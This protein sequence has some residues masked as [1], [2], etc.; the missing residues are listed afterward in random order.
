[1]PTF[2][3]HQ[4]A[5]IAEELHKLIAK[6]INKAIEEMCRKKTEEYL[7]AEEVAQMLKLSK[8]QI[9][10][11]KDQ[12]G[13][14]YVGKALRFLKSRVIYVVESGYGSNLSL[15]NKLSKNK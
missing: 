7:T 5:L 9:Y 2:T 4:A 3:R 6:D 14:V 13:C 10:Q 12:I 11:L 8:H 1:M 15:N